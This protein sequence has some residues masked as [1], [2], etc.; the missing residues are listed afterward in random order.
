MK[1]IRRVWQNQRG[2][3]LITIPTNSNI[4][5]GDYVEVKKVK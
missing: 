1:I 3:L 2:Q 5:K 4:K